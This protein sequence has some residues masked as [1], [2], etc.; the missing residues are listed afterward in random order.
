MGDLKNMLEKLEVFQDWH[1]F[2]LAVTFICLEVTSSIYYM[3]KI[4]Y[5]DH[6]GKNNLSISYFFQE[7][8]IQDCDFAIIDSNGHLVGNSRKNQNVTRSLASTK[9]NGFDFILY[10]GYFL[11]ENRC[12][13]GSVVT[14]VIYAKKNYSRLR[15]ADN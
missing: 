2:L 5:T 14:F 3:A 8:I 4:I 12:E 9:Q 6:F 1:G 13:N 11:Q 10:N 7:K 15:H